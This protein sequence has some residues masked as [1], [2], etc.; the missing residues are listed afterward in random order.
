[1]KNKHSLLRATTW[2]VWRGNDVF[3]TGISDS[4]SEIISV[5]KRGLL[6]L[7]TRDRKSST[8]IQQFML[9][10]PGRPMRTV[11]AE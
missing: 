4:V 7:G 2:W 10:F 5:Q 9:P 11:D 3:P 6:H 1:M 8:G